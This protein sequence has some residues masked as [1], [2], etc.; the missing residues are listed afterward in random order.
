MRTIRVEK[1]KAAELRQYAREKLDVTMPATTNRP[2][3]LKLLQDMGEAIDGTEIEISDLDEA[4]ETEQE[5]KEDT[6]T[7][8]VD[9]TDA[10]MAALIATGMDESEAKHLAGRAVQEEAATRPFPTGPEAD[11]MF[12][13]IRLARTEEAG[14][15]E[16][17]PVGVNG[18]VMLVPRGEDVPVRLPYVEVLRHAQKIVY[19]QR[20]EE[21]GLRIRYI[22]HIVPRYPIESMS[23]PYSEAVAKRLLRERADIAAAA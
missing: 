5:A 21:D 2:N 6:V 9:R 15:E 13:T 7:K 17:V 19:T 12:C 18:D 4:A 20:L 14:G 1:A 10:L 16:A 8:P 22:P 3:A 23:A 11:Q